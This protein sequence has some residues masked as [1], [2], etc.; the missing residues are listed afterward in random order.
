MFLFGEGDG[1][2]DNFNECRLGIL[3]IFIRVVN[4]NYILMK[5]FLV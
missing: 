3:M 1:D 4:V 5:I 2:G